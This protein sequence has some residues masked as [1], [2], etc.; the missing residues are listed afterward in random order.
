[1]SI[2]N[3]NLIK[4]NLYLLSFVSKVAKMKTFIVAFNMPYVR[5]IS[6]GLWALQLPLLH[7]TWLVVRTGLALQ[8]QVL[9]VTMVQR[10]KQRL[11]FVE[12][13]LAQLLF[14][15]LVQLQFVVSIVG[16]DSASHSLKS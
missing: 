9:L 11:D 7:K 15:Q 2:I 14:Q 10:L 13:N 5:M 4:N 1:M 16:S 3:V 8:V 6:P 12:Q